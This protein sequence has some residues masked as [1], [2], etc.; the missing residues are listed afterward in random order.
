M[1]LLKTCG[2]EILAV[3]C[4][5]KYF[6]GYTL[7]EACFVVSLVTVFGLMGL[8]IGT[9]NWRHG[10]FR[11]DCDMVA[12]AV[13][14][15]RNSAISGAC[16]GAGC[17]DSRPQGVYFD[18][19]KRGILIFQG[20]DYIHR[21]QTADESVG[22]ENRTTSISAS[23]SVEVVFDRFGNALPVEVVLK[24]EIDQSCTITVSAV[25]RIDW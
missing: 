22:F 9:E 15:A 4:E 23:S 3:N 7:L 21:Q 12:A 25:G 5:K 24:N 1:A 6:R 13:L 18:P 17:A 14:K 11:A 8:C 20:D 16:Y 2:N 10:S 19:V